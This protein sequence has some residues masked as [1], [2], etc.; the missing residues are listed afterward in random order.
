MP[1]MRYNT[2][3]MQWRKCNTSIEYLFAI[4]KRKR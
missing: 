1:T 2:T 4:S 3:E